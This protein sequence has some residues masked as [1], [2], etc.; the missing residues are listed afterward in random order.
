M[1]IN[2]TDNALLIPIT[3]DKVYTNMEVKSHCEC[4]R[5]PDPLARPTQI[6]TC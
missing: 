4:V 6:L 5:E 2:G 3:K 1:L